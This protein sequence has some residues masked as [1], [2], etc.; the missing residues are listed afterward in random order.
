MI[1]EPQV[2]GHIQRDAV[3]RRPAA[4]ADTDR[5][6]FRSAG[7]HPGVSVATFR[8]NSEIGADIDEHR[9]EAPYVAMYVSTAVRQADD[10][11]GDQLPRAVK[12]HPATAA[13]PVGWYAQ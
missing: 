6:D 3:K 11:I 4:H 1:E 2:G 9:F 13:H 7:P 12:G 10:R 8:R 5:R